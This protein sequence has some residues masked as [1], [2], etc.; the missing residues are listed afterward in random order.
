MVNEAVVSIV[1]L[2]VTV[3]V[4][5]FISNVCSF[6]RWNPGSWRSELVRQRSLRLDSSGV[7]PKHVCNKRKAQRQYPADFDRHV[8]ACL[9]RR[10]DAHNA[11]SQRDPSKSA[12]RKMAGWFDWN[13]VGRALSS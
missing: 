9:Q 11:H 8:E 13:F 6:L 7:C 12:A 10:V 5:F 4:S 2:F 1:S 3:C